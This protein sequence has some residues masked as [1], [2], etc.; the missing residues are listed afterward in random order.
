MISPLRRLQ[1]KKNKRILFFTKFFLELKSLNGVIQLF[2][3]SR[4][5]DLSQI[6]LLSVIWPAVILVTDTPSSFLADKYGRK[7]MMTLG[8]FF[9]VVSM[10]LL[11]FANGFAQVALTY[12]LLAVGSSFYNGAD[13]AILYDSL[14][15]LG[16]E[17]GATRV[18]GKYFSAA[19][20]PKII[21]PLLGS[22]IASGLAYWQFITLI[23]IDIAGMLLALFATSRLVEP[24]LHDYKHNINFT[25]LPVVFSS[26][27]KNKT[28]LKLTFN[29][30]LTF[31]AAFVFWRVYQ[32]FLSDKGLGVVWL[33]LVYTFFQAIMF[34]VLW[35]Y[36][37]IE[38]KIGKTAFVAIPQILGLFSVLICIFTTN[39]SLLFIATVIGLTVGT[40]RDPFF[41]SQIQKELS[42]FNRATT[43][44][45]LN[46]IRNVTDIVVLL[47]VGFLVSINIYYIL[48]VSAV[49]FAAALLFFPITKRD[50]S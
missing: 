26:I 27:I 13:Q 41:V 38:N 36:S 21:T 17:S 6:V 12:V 8:I 14:K 2:Y 7:K 44:S 50:V 34:F 30:V 11:F 5:L 10:V 43:T 22:I 23:A 47:F 31:E 4:G 33:G 29:K 32:V 40:L 48:W 24:K 46:T 42:S 3:L 9:S 15:E 1:L 28:L 39:L 20:L 16:D 25:S 49:L 35:N 19:S 37:K 18:A 45:A